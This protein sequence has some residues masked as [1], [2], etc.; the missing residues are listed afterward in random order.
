M[1]AS[2]LVSNPA[3]VLGGDLACWCG[4]GRWSRC[5]RTARFGLLQC[6]GCGGYRIDP[7]PLQHESQ[8]ETFYTD[9]YSNLE[10]HGQVS[11]FRKVGRRV[12]E[13]SV[14][15]LAAAD[16]GCGDG[17]L[18]AELSSIGWRRVIGIE[19][20]R[21]RVARA[22]KRYP[23]IEFYDCPL[24]KTGIPQN[25]LDL[26]TMDSVI[27]HLLDPVAI[28]KEI[29]SRMKST[30]RLLLLTP[31]MESGH[32]RFLG[33][34]WTGMLAPHAHIFLFTAD[35]LRLL[36]KMAGFDVTHSGSLHAPLYT[37]PEWVRRVVSGD[38]KGA[39]WRAHQEIGAVYGKLIGAGPMLYTVA[40]PSGS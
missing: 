4:S 29:R 34:R 21:T 32:F 17:H 22:R 38:V 24:G 14:P 31:N 2:F 6:T 28:L 3:P 9:Y 27:E 25:S 35:S 13:L 5:F 36:L 7:P 37:V 19:V 11:W 40:Q 8:S 15:G 26:V 20:S 30:S 16:I 33:R 10:V 18:C 39:V 12:P 1:S 23:N